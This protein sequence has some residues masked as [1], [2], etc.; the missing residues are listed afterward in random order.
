M[1]QVAGL[2]GSA[3]AFGSAG[4]SVVCWDE[5]WLTR[6]AYGEREPATSAGRA[7]ITAT[8]ALAET[9]RARNSGETMQ[10]RP[11]NGGF[12]P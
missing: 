3:G 11:G 8:T 10:I 1:P 7:L 5:R 9:R 6:P 2:P 4:R 12:L